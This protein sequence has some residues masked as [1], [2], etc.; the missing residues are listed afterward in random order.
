[1]KTY[2]KRLERLE[3]QQA[4]QTHGWR[5][6]ILIETHHLSVAEREQRIAE[7]EAEK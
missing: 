5:R 6:H 1:M 4:E 7:A 2:S 3:S